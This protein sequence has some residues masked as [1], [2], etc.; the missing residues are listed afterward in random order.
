MNAVNLTCLVKI[1]NCEIL[2]IPLEVFEVDPFVQIYCCERSSVKL[3]KCIRVWSIYLARYE[4]VALV[5]IRAVV[6][7]AEVVIG[8]SLRRAARVGVYR[9]SVGA[10]DNCEVAR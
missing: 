3:C 4:Q 5:I 8:V 7:F 10:F 6:K 9:Y 1:I 2:P